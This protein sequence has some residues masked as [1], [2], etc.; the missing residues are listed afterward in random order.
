[1]K[2]EEKDSKT[3]RTLSR[4]G[5][6]PPYNDHYKEERPSERERKSF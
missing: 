4:S 2:S 6:Q 5:V 3:Y 1:M